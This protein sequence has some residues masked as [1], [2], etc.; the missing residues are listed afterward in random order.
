MARVFEIAFNLAAQL[1]SSFNSTFGSAASQMRNLQTNA[2]SLRAGLRELETAQR[3]GRISASEYAAQQQRLA[4]QLARTERAQRNLSRA[5]RMQQNVGNV[6]DKAAGAMAT[7]AVGVATFAL[8]I[9]AAIKY[10]SA[11]S[12]V[13]KQV[14]G[15]RD[16]AGNLTS[17]Y[18]TMS[19]Q[20]M[21]A[22]KDMMIMPD[23][24][25]E[26]FVM[27]AKSGVKG[28]ENIERFA[29][30]GV[31][32][33][34]AFEAPAAAVTEQF[35]KIGSAMGINLETSEGI[36][37]LGAL[38]DVVNYLDDQTNASGAD[39]ISVIKDI[40]GTATSL[41]PT[42]SSGTLAGMSAAMLNMGETAGTTGTALNA[43]FTK[44]AAAPTQGK[45]FKDALAEIGYTAEE[46]QAGSLQDAEGTI[47]GL[48]EK[49]GQLDGASRNNV[50]AELFGA[51]YIS[52]MSKISGNYDQFLETIKKGNSEAAKGSMAKEFAIQSETV[53]RKL[54]GVKVAATHTAISIGQVLLPSLI[55]ITQ[56][57]MQISSRF[58]EWSEKNPELTSLIVKT[59]AGVAVLSLAVATTAFAFSSVI[60]PLMTFGRWMFMARVATDGM[61][62]AS[63]ASAMWSGICAG[64]TSAW[65]AAQWLW[66]AALTANPIGLVI[67]GIAAL[68]AAGY[69]LIANW[70]TVKTWFSLLWNDPMAALSSFASGIMEKLS[71]P[72]Q[73]LEDKWIKLGSLLAGGVGGV[74]ISSVDGNDL[75]GHATGGIFNRE[76]IA[77][78][79]EG[80]KPE[81]V[82]PLNGSADALSLWA[83][84]GSILGMMPQSGAQSAGFGA[85]LS[86]LAGG[87]SSSSSNG[88]GS[89]IQATFSPVI[90]IY[91]TPEKG[92]VEREVSNGNRSFLDFLHNESRLS[93][94]D[95]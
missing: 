90:T 44:I 76:H 4:E 20:I 94:N 29:K 62:L 88:T 7:A 87:T 23:I 92:Q 17:V 70:D 13:A 3:T 81:A 84:A 24:M 39:I 25:A 30:M 75:P 42:L 50:L 41:L 16:D 40:S 67:M 43:L 28:A 26:S 72:L 65:T 55:E 8:P 10:D 91:G 54:D 73:W 38:A 83:Q 79:A 14:E 71:G 60:L 77:R 61:V 12:G 59:A 48:F 58:A 35:A 53:A 68:I 89:I 45:P 19:Q 22:S 51:E 93:F 47:T 64:A 5:M 6:K 49:I 52:S 74:S 86:S 37:K 69:L 57:V 78:F 32:M 21:L 9:A 46:L 63:R 11:M 31:M 18:T 95:G 34:T 27:A 33:G 1:G 56:K 15:A 2:S 66:N 85:G 36:D 80:G 82:I